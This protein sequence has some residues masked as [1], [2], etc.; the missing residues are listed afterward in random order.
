MNNRGFTLI[1]ILVAVV[2]LGVSL[3][4]IISLFG[5]GLR[6]VNS[7]ENY[8]R[9]LLLAREKLNERLSDSEEFSSGESFGT[10]DGYEWEY[11]VSPLEVLQ[12]SEGA[13]LPE[14]LRIEMRVRWKE[15]V[16]L[17]ELFLYGLTP[18]GVKYAG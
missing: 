5:G 10:V 7:T 6:L 4:L 12:T 3:S 17:K 1:E 8:S 18:I 14:L 11:S 16:R 15:G 13:S 9:A 2:I